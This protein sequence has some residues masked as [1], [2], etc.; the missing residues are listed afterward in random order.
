[1]SIKRLANEEIIIKNKQTIRKTN[2]YAI[3]ITKDI[4][5]LECKISKNTKSTEISIIS[6]KCKVYC[7]TVSTGIFMV[8]KN[9]KCYWTGNSSR[10]G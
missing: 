7:P 8:R 10:S 6:K 5:S 3:S 9:G 2:Q 1:L 4:K